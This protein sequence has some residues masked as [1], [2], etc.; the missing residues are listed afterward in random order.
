MYNRRKRNFFA[1]C[2]VLAG[3]LVSF[4]AYAEEGFVNEGPGVSATAEEEAFAQPEET[5]ISLGTF[6]ITGYCGCERCSGG[7]TLTY[8]GTRP[9]ANHTISADLS[10]FPLGTRLSIN[11]TVYTVE[12]KGSSVHGNILDIYYDTHEEALANGTYYAEVFLETE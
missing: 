9:Q 3:S 2:L 8:S 6:K 10:Q 4:P 12:D 1:L 5:E 7:N 11:G